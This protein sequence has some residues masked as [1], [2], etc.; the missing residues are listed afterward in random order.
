MRSETIEWDGHRWNR[1]PDS[2]RRSDRVYFKRS[3]KGGTAWLHREIWKSA[4]GEIPKGF[5]IHHKDGNTLNNSL[6]NL[7]CLSVKEH[8][9]EHPLVG[10]QYEKQLVHLEE[11]REKTKAWHASPEGIEWHRKHAKEF[12]WGVPDLPEKACEHC[13][14][15]FKPK[16]YHEKFCSNACKSAWRRKEGLDDVEKPC[17]WCGRLF[18][19]NKYAKVRF[20]C[21][22]CAA[23]YRGRQISERFRLNRSGQA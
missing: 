14:K 19:S 2:E 5:H 21:R 1:Y 6:D 9:H 12:H 20:C 17:E 15:L 10:E 16:T 23:H 8:R 13:G 7:V 4:Y 22:A 3:I 11:I 18:T